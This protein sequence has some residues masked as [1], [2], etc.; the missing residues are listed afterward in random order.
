MTGDFNRRPPGGEIP[1]LALPGVAPASRPIGQTT[2]AWAT[3][4]WL[5]AALAHT[6]ELDPIRWGF[7]PKLDVCAEPWSAKAPRWYGPGGEREDAHAEPWDPDTEKWCNPPYSLIDPWI[8]AALRCGSAARGA[9]MFL[10]PP[11]TGRP[12]Y[13]QLAM[14]ARQGWAWRFLLEG[15]VEFIPPAG[16]TGGNVGGYVELWQVGGVA[17]RLPDF[18]QVEVLKEIGQARLRRQGQD[19]LRQP[20]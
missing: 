20:R 10:L 5:V 4:D 7:R 16:L 6:R 15:R 13:T 17:P 14:A 12:W 18:M 19:C 1:Q 9:T 2:D 8:H 3:P 11:R